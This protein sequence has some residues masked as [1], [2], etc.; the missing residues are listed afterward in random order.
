MN[1]TTPKHKELLK[2]KLNQIVDNVKSITSSIE[3]TTYTIIDK[4]DN[5]VNLALSEPSSVPN[6]YTFEDYAEYID[7][8]HSKI[9]KILNELNKI[10]EI[11]D[12]DVI[13]IMN[14]IRN[15]DPF[16]I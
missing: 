10:Q 9:Y 15:E 3:P 8:K 12:N 4:D 14:I 7:K 5:A 13:R 11:P 6:F 16:D 2:K 1:L